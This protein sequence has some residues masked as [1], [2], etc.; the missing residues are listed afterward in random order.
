MADCPICERPLAPEPIVGREMMFGWGDAFTYHRC[1][2]CGS[3]W[4]DA[5]PADLARFYP[6]DY[7][8]YASAASSRP[9]GVVGRTLRAVRDRH[10]L[11][12]RGALGRILAARHDYPE[13]RSVGRVPGLAPG[14]AILDVGC[15]DAQLL[16]R[17]AALGFRDLTGLEP[18]AAGD[19]VHPDGVRVRRATL[20]QVDGRWDLVMMHHSL[21]HVP[22]PVGTLRAI[23]ARLAPGGTCLLRVPVVPSLAWDEF[24]THWVGLDAPRH[25]WIPSVEGLTRLGARFGLGVRE[26]AYDATAFSY[27]ASEQYARGVPLR[28]AHSH[29]VDPARSGY[30]AERIA[31]LEAKARAANAAGRADSAVI[32]LAAAGA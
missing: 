20:D 22:D 7:Y 21:E 3:L 17:L 18:F 15:G 14:S 25:L 29:A 28:A 8:S 24:G 11:T 16:R 6:G 19:T 30:T 2:G 27:W 4:I 10:L 12:G 13:L 31:A 23:A 9:L 5:V 26:V 1:P 32:H